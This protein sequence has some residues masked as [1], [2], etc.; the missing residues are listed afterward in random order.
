MY[1][2]SVIW[3]YI[4]QLGLKLEDA[5]WIL[6]EMQMVHAWLQENPKIAQGRVRKLPSPK[7]LREKMYLRG[8]LLRY[9]EDEKSSYGLSERGQVLLQMISGTAGMVEELPKNRWLPD[10]KSYPS[11]YEQDRKIPSHKSGSHPCSG[12][13]INANVRCGDC[14]GILRERVK[15]NQST[16]LINECKIRFGSSY[17]RSIPAGLIPDATGVVSWEMPGFDDYPGCTAFKQKE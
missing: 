16:Y 11:W 4:Q 10:L 14:Q 15:N 12:K 7:A 17:Q 8:I 9:L 1:R 3:D 2:L 13:G 5:V 6:E